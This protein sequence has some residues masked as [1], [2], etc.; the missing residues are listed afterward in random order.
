[1]AQPQPTYPHQGYSAYD[2]R[3]PEEP[4]P[5]PP[6]GP[7]IHLLAVQGDRLLTQ[8]AAAATTFEMADSV[9]TANGTI[10]LGESRTPSLFDD[11]ELAS[12]E[13][14]TAHM[15]TGRAVQRVLPQRGAPVAYH[16]S[17]CYKC[18]HTGHLARECMSPWKLVECYNCGQAGH[19]SRMC[20]ERRPARPDL[21]A[22]STRQVGGGVGRT[23]LPVCPRCGNFN[24]R[25]EKC[26]TDMD[27][28][29]QQCGKRGHLAAECRGGMSLASYQRAIRDLDSPTS[30]NGTAP[31][32]GEGVWR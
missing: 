5:W 11:S 21:L 15:T 1:M 24:H 17:Q 19:I 14:A 7:W 20:P 22:E 31:A 4:A 18:G 6:T 25:A 8:N 26:H 3:R 10:H 16:A 28:I 29:C 27:K 9:P 32:L 30:K 13:A 12:T 23:P 2:E